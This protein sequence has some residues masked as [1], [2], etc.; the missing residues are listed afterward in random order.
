ML[1]GTNAQFF[2]REIL[3]KISEK[4]LTHMSEARLKDLERLTFALTLYNFN[5]PTSKPIFTEVLKE[6]YKPE[7]QN[8]FEKYPRC[9]SS[10][11]H[12]LGLQQIYPHDLISKVLDNEF[13]KFAYGKYRCMK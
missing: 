12:Y 8:E 6:L 1:A 9:L 2:N 13:L 7:R 11:L 3:T 5:P 10:C 4:F